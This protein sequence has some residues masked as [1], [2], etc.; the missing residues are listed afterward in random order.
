MFMINNDDVTENANVFYE[1]VTV[2]TIDDDGDGIGLKDFQVIAI[3]RHDVWE[4]SHIY[5]DQPESVNE[6]TLDCFA[7][8]G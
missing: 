6:S 4:S 2:T 8:V 1:P 5:D 3:D 7:F